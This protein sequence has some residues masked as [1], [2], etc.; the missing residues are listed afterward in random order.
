[1]IRRFRFLFYRAVEMLKEV[2]LVLY[3][4]IPYPTLLYSRKRSVP[5]VVSMTS[6]PARIEQV[7]IAIETLRRQTVRPEKIVLVLNTVE[8][9]GKKIPQQVRRLSK[10]AVEVMW[11]SQNGFS[12]D[13]LLPVIEAFPQATIVTVDDDKYFPR[14]MLEA[15]HESSL[16]YPGSIIGA[17]GW[18]IKPRLS[19]NTYHYGEGWSRAVREQVG[20]NL[21]TPGGNGCLYPPGSLHPAGMNAEDALRECPTADDIWFWAASRKQQTSTVCL[22]LPAHRPITLGKNSGALSDANAE[23]NDQQFHNAI[24]FFALSKYQGSDR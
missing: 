14:H 8:F 7:W 23:L 10:K 6:Y 24:R 4:R 16:R 21:L 3:L 22:G 9:P 15:L 5:L 1:M 20:H 2:A 17:R 11:V 13:K 18:V 12:Y 19:D